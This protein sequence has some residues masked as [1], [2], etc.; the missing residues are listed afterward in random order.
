MPDF[1]KAHDRG[2]FSL[3]CVSCDTWQVCV[4]YH[5]ETNEKGGKMFQKIQNLQRIGVCVF[6]KM[7]SQ[8]FRD[9]KIATQHRKTSIQRN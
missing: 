6:F 9:V 4:T 1:G 7:P 8:V 2:G 3:I 5:R